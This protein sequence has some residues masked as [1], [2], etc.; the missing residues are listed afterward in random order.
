M[1]ASKKNRFSWVGQFLAFVPGK[2]SL[3]QSAI[4]QVVAVEEGAPIDTIQSYQIKLDK[5]IREA[6]S[7]SIEAKDWIKIAGKGKP[8]KKTGKIE[9]KASTIKKV[10]LRKVAKVKEEAKTRSHSVQSKSLSTA[11]AKPTRILVCQKSSCRKK[12]SQKV[13]DAMEKAIANAEASDQVIVKST[14][15][16]KCCKTGPTVVVLPANDKNKKTSK[17]RHRKVTPK[18]AK[19]IVASVL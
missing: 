18:A 13:S 14:G 2:K 10:S 1:V 6:A 12:G 9:W 4:V 8:D 7:H 16:L 11:K 15:C 5:D 3:Y 19:K 17:E